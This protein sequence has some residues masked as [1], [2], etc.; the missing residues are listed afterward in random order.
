MSGLQA[1]RMQQTTNRKDRRRARKLGKQRPASPAMTSGNGRPHNPDFQQAAEYFSAGR[2]DGAELAC[3]RALKADPKHCEAHLVLA[4]LL[5]QRRALEDAFAHYKAAV[6]LRPDKVECWQQFGLCLMDLNQ[7]DAAEIAYKKAIELQPKNPQLH[8]LLAV[9]HYE[10]HDPPAA[11]GACD[12]ALELDPDLAR[13]HNEKGKQHQ[14]LGEVEAA[15]A[16]F[17]RAAEL[18]P[19]NVDYQYRL[20]AMALSEEED[21]ALL[22]SL[23]DLSARHALS[24]QERSVVFFAKGLINRRRK[25]F[26]EA[27]ACYAEANACV[28]AINRFDRDN[29]ARLVDQTI[30]A[31]PE[32]V[33]EN[34]TSVGSPSSR[35]VFIVGMPRSGSTL[36]EQ[37][38]SSH[39]SAVGVGEL[40]KLGQISEALIANREGEFRYPR[41]AAKISPDHLS[42]IAA[43]YLAELSRRVG[44]G[45]ERVCD[46]LL[47]N[48]FNLGLIAFLFPNA[49][50][51]DCQRNPMD[52][53]LSCFMQ[54]FENVPGLAFANSLEDIGFCYRQYRRLMDH[55][56][57]VLP[58]PVLE[59]CYEELVEDHEAVSRT[60][61]DHVGL[62]WDESCLR[63]YEA[64]RSVKTSSVLQVRREI[65]RTAVDRWKRYERHLKPL[66]EALEGAGVS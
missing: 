38:I 25:R 5:Q 33:F 22:T 6:Q 19:R 48:F 59:V 47:F 34:R 44:D 55:W 29:F 7:F 20:A 15:Q 10:R 16:C 31:F 50:I 11:I 17:R 42:S 1:V 40:P 3:R 41:D 52:L 12:R 54:Y 14:S 30:A 45:P 43:D 4:G 66:Q 62:E 64:K 32:A 61:I 26:D 37:I 8:M 51:I 9:A 28:H 63:F 13:A 49:A 27:F 56:N 2:Y 39:P 58:K 57:A 23:N 46:K 53:G 36:I 65:N 60:I 35:P 24:Q 21:N 18:D